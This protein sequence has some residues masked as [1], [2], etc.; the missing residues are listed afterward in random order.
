M[1][2]SSQPNWAA[3]TSTQTGTW[4]VYDADGSG[5]AYV[6]TLGFG[7]RVQSAHNVTAGRRSKALDPNGPTAKMLLSVIK[8]GSR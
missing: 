2:R 1:S 5:R 3:K 4:H 6:V 7:G 8:G